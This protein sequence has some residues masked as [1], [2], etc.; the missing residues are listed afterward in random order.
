M[1]KKNLF[2]FFLI[3]FL[4]FLMLHCAT[5]EETSLQEDNSVDLIDLAS[6]KKNKTIATLL[7]EDINLNVT[8]Q[9][10]RTPLHIAV[11]TGNKEL[12]VTLLK[13]GAD[14]NI[15]DIY[16]LTPLHIAVINRNADICKILVDYKADVLIETEMGESPLTLAFPRDVSLIQVMI[17]RDNVNTVSVN[18]ETILHLAV[19]KGYYDFCVYLLD[20]GADVQAEDKD[21][22]RPIDIA[23]QFSDDEYYVKIAA[24]LIE[25]NS[26]APKN[27]DLDY[28]YQI[29]L[30]G[31][32]SLR[33]DYGKTGLH[34]AA[35]RDHSGIINYLLKSENLYIDVNSQDNTGNTPL[36][37]A[38]WQGNFAITKLLLNKGA[39]INKT[40]S[41]GNT[42]LH[43]ALKVKD[44]DDI[45]EY[46]V[47]CD[48]DVNAKNSYGNTPLHIAAGMNSS[49]DVILLLIESGALVNSRNKIGNTPLMEALEKENKEMVFLLVNNDADIF[50]IN[51]A[52]LSPA[53]LALSKGVDT[54]N[55]F[56][57]TGLINAMDN[58]GRTPLHIAVENNMGLD[59]LG[60][61]IDMGA[62]YNA[63][64][65]QGDTPFHIA[66][67]NRNLNY[68]DYF[69]S[70][71]ADPFVKNNNGA[72]PFSIAVGYDLSFFN[73][74]LPD[75]YIN[76]P[77]NEG[78]TPLFIAIREKADP[79]AELLVK[80][81][82]ADINYKN[83]K[84]ETPLFLAVYY[85]NKKIAKLLIESGADVNSRDNYGNTPLFIVTTLS[86]PIPIGSYLISQGADL[87]AKNFDGQSILHHASINGNAYFIRYLLES[88]S[89]INIID[90]FG[91]TPLF[92]AVREDYSD[93][94]RYLISSGASLGY[95]DQEGNTVLHEAMENERYEIADY[96]LSRG[97][98]I[99]AVNKRGKTPFDIA[100]SKGPEV[101]DWF[102]DSEN[103]FLFDNEGNTPLHYAVS[104]KAPK[105]ILNILISK[106]SDINARNSKG[107]RPYDIAKDLGY[108]D[109]YDILQPK[110]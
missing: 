26:Y 39:D 31:N 42:P 16:G 96:L 30:S 14:P 4:S 78:E 18:S 69:F 104:R 67:R 84:G 13:N 53:H 33:F 61:L 40:N 64:N 83:G 63:R 11:E 102:F 103:I 25:Y 3:I 107:K 35:E 15:Q 71:G 38:A 49:P 100:I 101:I 34:F 55:W 36:H 7:N 80:Q 75:E 54:I 58:N 81:R 24:L 27:P 19:K 60:A 56:F 22:N 8:D 74:F 44:N 79:I 98:D 106:G 37:I 109:V 95:R 10:G 46:L 32:P 89:N 88:G 85:E 91:R 21:G 52:R 59:I 1:N 77:D 93:I 41:F 17:N 92:Y 90:N 5:Q 43:E 72:S 110:K 9:E 70:L 6:K 82:G 45:V 47:N 76:K 50:A 65:A 68:T 105:E 48:A 28:F 12:T 87:N 62:D 20:I 99:F 29:I 2:R 51:N 94:V 86:D 66:A 23:M 108:R 73:D 57:S 97:G